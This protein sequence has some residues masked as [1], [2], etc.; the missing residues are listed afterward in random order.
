MLRLETRDA[1]AT[2][3][4]TFDADAEP[5][6]DVFESASRFVSHYLGPPSAAVLPTRVALTPPDSTVYGLGAPG[7]VAINP[8]TPPSLVPT[9]AAHELFHAAFVGHSDR[10]ILAPHISQSQAS[11][12][13]SDAAA[14]E[15]AG[16]TLPDA[17]LITVPSPLGFGGWFALSPTVA[18]DWHRAGNA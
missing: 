16:W 5:F 18:A 13:A 17:P 6:R 14:I 7:Y 9:V 11:V 15:D 2:F 12:T 1:A 4:L 10:G 8:Q 3:A